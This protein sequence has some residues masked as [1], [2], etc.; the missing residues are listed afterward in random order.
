MHIN[1]MRKTLSLGSLRKKAL[2]YGHNYMG[3]R[4]T[5]PWLDRP[6]SDASGA[7]VSSGPDQLQS[8]SASMMKRQLGSSGAG[9]HP[10]K[11]GAFLKRRKME[12]LD[13]AYPEFN[14]EYSSAFFPYHVRQHYGLSGD[15][16]RR[17]VANVEGMV[18]QRGQHDDTYARPPLVPFVGEAR[19]TSFQI[20]RPNNDELPYPPG[21]IASRAATHLLPHDSH[22]HSQ[23]DPYGG[24]QEYQRRFSVGAFPPLEDAKQFPK[25]LN[26][27]DDSARTATASIPSPLGSLSSSASRADHHC[28]DPSQTADHDQMSSQPS[29]PTTKI[30][31]PPIHLPIEERSA[32][33]PQK[34]SSSRN[35]AVE[36]STC[37]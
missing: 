1:E 34:R 21:P 32:G 10:D 33:S 7:S 15:V 23:M 20:A 13:R 37:V 27:R 14:N 3:S 31:L 36:P 9:D 24:V 25:A 19:T 29:S 18:G 12:V 8:A 28:A 5:V 26:Q 2:Q 35:T 11:P 30:V 16:R 4:N 17:S 6:S 22:F